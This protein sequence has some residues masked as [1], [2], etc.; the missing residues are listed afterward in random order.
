MANEQKGR[1]FLLYHED[2]GSPASYT[3]IGGLTVT[4]MTI[5]NN[6]VDVTNKDSAGIQE[7]LADAGNQSMEIQADGR[8]KHT[9]GHDNL[10][11][12]AYNR[13]SENF[14]LDF[15]NG[16][17]YAADFVITSYQRAG[18]DGDAETFSISLAR[19]GAGTLTRA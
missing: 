6:P 15:G 14:R 4:S 9:A 5:N 7:F 10:E 13:A 1:D 17:S 3:L 2:S 11:D 18:A 8:Y 16:D 12:A 19:S